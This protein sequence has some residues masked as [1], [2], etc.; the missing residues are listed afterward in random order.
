VS[1]CYL[2]EDILRSLFSDKAASWVIYFK[3]AKRASLAF[4]GFKR[5]A[6]TSELVSGLQAC[7]S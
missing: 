1:P 2:F 7:S 5:S 6:K 3:L 4:A